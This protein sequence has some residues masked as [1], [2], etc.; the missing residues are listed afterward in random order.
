MRSTPETDHFESFYKDV[1]GS[2]V[3]QTYALTG[4]LSASQKAVRDALIVAWHHWRKVSRLDDPESWVRPLAWS[5]AQRRHT[6]RWWARQKDLDPASKDTLDAL[7]RLT[8]SQRKVLILSHLTSLPLDELAREAGVTRPT[9]EQELQTATAQF[10][11]HRDVASTSIRAVLDALGSEVATVRW[12]RA[13]I[14]FR[15]GTARRRSHTTVGV[16]AAVAAVVISGSLVTDAAGVRPQLSDKSIT[17]VPSSEGSRPAAAA[18]ALPRT[19]LVGADQVT[20]ALNSSWNEG[21]TSSNTDE[22][23]TFFPCQQGR[24]ADP[25]VV[26]AL[27]RTFNPDTGLPGDTSTDAPTGTAPDGQADAQGL[28][29]SAAPRT[30]LVPANQP[31]L[32][33]GVEL[34]ADEATA[35]RTYT[36]TV[37]WYTGCMSPRVQLRATRSVT[38][39]GD[40]AMMLSF[41]KWDDPLKTV[42]VTVARTG[43]LTTTVVHQV[44]GIHKPSYAASLSLAAK[45]VDGLCALPA[46]GACTTTP[47]M[48]DV[49]P[50]P[51]GT[52]PALLSELDLPPVSAVAEP[53]VGSD[54]K[55]A[56]TNV[57]AT[58]CD[59]ASFTG[60]GISSGV[61]RTFLVPGDTTLPP[62]FGLTQTAGAMTARKARSF[63][64]DVRAKMAACPQ[65]DLGTDVTRLV[66]RSDK[67]EDLTIWRLTVEVSDQASVTFLMA[68]MRTGTAVSQLTFVP[69]PRV[70][71]ARGAF[72]EL[73]ARALERLVELPAPS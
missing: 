58:R 32:G 31:M 5:R 9:V 50:V 12:P 51:T 2:L 68:I 65:D 4:D 10:S 6:A 16:A 41:R 62:E 7:G 17:S 8:T 67:R 38:G 70:T 21:R 48:S 52:Q 18:A 27:L 72:E 43:D 44:P 30:R 14:L 26:T 54:P 69:A 15:A 63:V 60:P 71:M 33:Q 37:G 34:S 53:W 20:A 47:A 59:K 46:G 1:R 35:E 19:A 56:D 73:T 57:A 28:A 61:T 11:L 49:P 3:L 23:G 36:T 42:V 55:P 40:E 39:V 25:A 45:A 22:K 24:Y 66:E 64:A 13:T 29:D